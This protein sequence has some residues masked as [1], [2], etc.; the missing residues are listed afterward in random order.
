MIV[1]PTTQLAMTRI[2]D[3]QPHASLLSGV[4]G[5]GLKTIALYIAKQLHSTPLLLEPDEKGSITTEKI[6]TLYRQTSGKKAT[7][8]VVVIDD[9]DMMTQSAQQAFLKLLEEPSANTMF[10]LT[11]HHPG[12]L[13]P[14]IMSRV[15]H[16]E[17]VPISEKATLSY[18]AT[19]TNA[20]SV[21]QRQL[22]YLALG[23][24]AELHRLTESSDYFDQKAAEIARAK[25]FVDGTDFE[26]LQIIHAI[27]PDRQKVVAL[28]EHTATILQLT[29]KKNPDQSRY[30]NELLSL[31]HAREKLEEDGNSKAQLL[32]A[33]FHS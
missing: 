3:T 7:A 25:Q 22:L 16:T 29:I 31:I 30:N 1:S 9:A 14:T 11:A 15:Q 24:P 19:L 12:N 8:Q 20:D 33:V 17:V 28:L 6:R 21:K 32:R 18:I 26:K 23:R 27:A 13:L 4:N 10:I 2:I 5:V